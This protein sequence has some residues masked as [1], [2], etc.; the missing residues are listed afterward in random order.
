MACSWLASVAFAQTEPASGAGSSTTGTNTYD[1][2]LNRTPQEGVEPAPGFTAAKLQIIPTL[3][4]SI[5]YDDNVTLAPS[6]EIS[7]WFYMISPAVRVELPSNHSVF[8]LIGAADIVR[9]QDSPIDNSLY[10]HLRAEWTWDISTRQDIN[11]F[12]QYSEGNDRRGEGRRQG[13]IGLI[14]LEPDEWELWDMGGKWDYG[15]VGAHGRLMLQGGAS[16]LTYTNNRGEIDGSP[17]T[18][19]LDRD[20]WF[21]GGTFYWRVAP[22]S[23]LLLDYLHTDINYKLSDSHNSTEDRLM[24][25]ITWDASARTSGTIKYGYLTKDFEDPARSDYSGPTWG[26][27]VDWRPRT[28]SVFT[29]SGTMETHEP[30][31]GGDY[32]LR[33]DI[34]LSWVHAWATRFG[35]TVDIGYSE[36][37]YR[38]TDRTDDLFY[39]GVGASYTYNT[40]FRFGASI[41]NYSRDSIESRFNYDNRVYMLSLEATY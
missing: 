24:A 8:S 30:D 35:T 6:N 16:D 40:H 22:K 4:L 12:A 9:Y 7:S 17:G 19:S 37:D 1:P 5:G 28:Y 2:M 25:G 3:G 20:W 41:T 23:S 39:W 10:W 11:L 14:P 33:R 29:L 18:R 13:T 36:D 31:G 15:A 26:L 32:V 38:P 27:S 21:Y 34:T